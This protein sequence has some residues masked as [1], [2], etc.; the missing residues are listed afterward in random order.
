MS[1]SRGEEKKYCIYMP[2]PRD[3]GIC[4]FGR[5]LICHH[6]YTLNS[7]IEPCPKVEKK[8][9]K[10]MKPFHYMTYVAMHAPTQELL[11]QRVMKFTIWKTHPWSS[12]LLYIYFV[13]SM[14]GNRWE[15]SRNTSFFSLLL[16]NFLS[17][18]PI[19]ATFQIW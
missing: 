7:L 6:Y 5:P 2:C 13:W 18:Y 14:T 10:E 8:T 12:L 17:P 9:F 15:F 16:Q 4:N 3:Y 11:S 19:Y 1:Q